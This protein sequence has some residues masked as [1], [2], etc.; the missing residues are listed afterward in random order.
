[1]L[2]LRPIKKNDPE[3]NRI[4]KIHYSQPGGFIGRQV[5]YQVVYDNVV[6]GAI[7]G[8]S[9]Y[10]HLPLRNNYF[11]FEKSD[12]EHLNKIINNTFYH[13]EPPEGGKYPVRNFAQ[14]VIKLW[15][16]TS[17]RDWKIKY[18]DDIY[19]WET[20]VEPPRTGE[21]YLR[22]GWTQLS[23]TKGIT[24]RQRSGKKVWN[25]NPAELR[26]KLVFVKKAMYIKSF[27]DFINGEKAE[28]KNP[29]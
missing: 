16:E 2:E 13:I 17:K 14:K 12:P 3:L 23:M 26:P 24:L 19:G 9:A 4:M 25:K 18:G 15:R 29:E 20:L 5:I 8:G 1:M 21:L 6:Y 27:G 11:G 7:V 22:D 10:M 28:N